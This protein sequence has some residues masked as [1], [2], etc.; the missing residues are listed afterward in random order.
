MNFGKHRGAGSQRR[1]TNSER[2]L[3]IVGSPSMGCSSVLGGD[4]SNPALKR[5]L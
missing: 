1:G 3:Q 4:Q 5:C 2:S